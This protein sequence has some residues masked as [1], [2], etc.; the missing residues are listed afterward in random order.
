MGKSIRE[1]A[2]CWVFD[3]RAALFLPPSVSV[4][5]HLGTPPRGS[6]EVRIAPLLISNIPSP[7]I[8]GEHD[9]FSCIYS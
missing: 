9:L 6:E 1:E 2:E 5:A 7:D 8:A 4:S 3:Y